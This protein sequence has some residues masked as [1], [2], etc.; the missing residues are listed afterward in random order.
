[1]DAIAVDAKQAPSVLSR[2]EN[3]DAYR[4]QWRRDDGG[5]IAD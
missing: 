5:Q 3:R 1:M 4:N 2:S